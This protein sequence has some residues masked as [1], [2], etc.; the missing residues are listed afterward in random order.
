[1]RAL[2]SKLTMLLGSVCAVGV[3]NAATG[4][5]GIHFDLGSDV[6]RPDAIAILHEGAEL[7]K[8]YPKTT[9]RI[10]GS[11]CVSEPDPDQLAFQRAYAARIF[12]LQHGVHPSQIR[13]VG[14]VPPRWQSQMRELY[15]DVTCAEHERR[16]M[17]SVEAVA[18]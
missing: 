10:D 14:I 16:A 5:N 9:I 4:F 7:L 13:S 15:R 8:T 18:P 6:L 12:L 17:V 3:A 2:I 11:A 1:M